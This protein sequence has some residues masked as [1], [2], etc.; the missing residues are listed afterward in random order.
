MKPP[1]SFNRI[2][3]R[4]RYDVKTATLIAHDAYWDGQNHE[5][6]GRNTFLYRTPRGAFFTVTLTQW[7]GERDSLTPVTQD[8]AIKL[9]E[10]QL[11]EHEVFY[12]DAFPGVEV[13]DA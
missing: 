1:T 2:I 8:E 4:K 13:D 5:R 12:A 3:D 10:G 6:R 11:C 7:E 9:Y